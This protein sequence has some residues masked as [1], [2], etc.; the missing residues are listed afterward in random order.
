MSTSNTQSS[1]RVS[2]VFDQKRHDNGSWELCFAIAGLLM[3]IGVSYGLFWF[4]I[5]LIPPLMGLAEALVF[6]VFPLGLSIAAVL[7]L[8]LLRRKRRRA[9]VFLVASIGVLAI[10]GVHAAF[11][12]PRVLSHLS[13]C[14]PQSEEVLDK[15]GPLV[16]ITQYSLDRIPPE[17]ECP[18][19]YGYSAFPWFR[20][21]AECWYIY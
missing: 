6:F 7:V 4:R 12:A 16:C 13:H 19:Y 18:I 2:P 9:S 14:A 21:V 15:V 8:L 3:G 20:V 5:Y 17:P 1:T 11:S 10:S